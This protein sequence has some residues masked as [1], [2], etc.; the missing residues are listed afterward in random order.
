MRLF[1]RTNHT[2]Q[3]TGDSGLLLSDLRVETHHA[4][5]TPEVT[6][7]FTPEQ[8]DNYTD[9]LNK[10]EIE[11]ITNQLSF[12]N[13]NNNVENKDSLIKKIITNYITNL[14]VYFNNYLNVEE[15]KFLRNA[16]SSQIKTIAISLNEKDQKLKNFVS[17][18]AE[19]YEVTAYVANQTQI[20]QELKNTKN[21]KHRFSYIKQLIHKKLNNNQ[22]LEEF[23]D[24]LE[25][26]LL[27]SR[28]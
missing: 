22:T 25:K 13:E 6:S 4:V 10:R 11:K 21:Q 3:E 28:V 12:V 1:K 16:D 5:K 2:P 23:I 18:F 15:I 24:D 19:P 7:A 9:K 26:S 17:Q 8:L 20:E 27:K 14:S